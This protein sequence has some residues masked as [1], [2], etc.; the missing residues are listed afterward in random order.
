MRPQKIFTFC[1]ISIVGSFF[2]FWSGGRQDADDSSPPA[3]SQ[4]DPKPE[5]V[6]DYMVVFAFQRDFNEPRYS[7]T[8]ATFVRATERGAST[9]AYPNEVHTLSWSPKSLNIV[10]L[11][12]RPE[13]GVNLDLQ[14]SLDWA[15]SVQARVTAWGPYRIQEELYQAARNQ[16]DRL[17]SGTVAYKAFKLLDRSDATNCIYALADIEQGRG[18]LAAGTAHGEA[19]SAM[20]LRH[21]QH[22][23]ID[24]P[25][26]HDWVKYR[27]GLGEHAVTFKSFP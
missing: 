14:A 19:A 13:P 8:F 26:T 24:L 9:E 22:R 23:I 17:N 16:I 1:G 11:R 5:R 25:Q 18:L 12:A 2:L 27:L 3:T 10:I 20:V 7:H 21:F 4:L 15:A 6:S